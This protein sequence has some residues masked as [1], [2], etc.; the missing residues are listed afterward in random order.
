MYDRTSLFLHSTAWP[1][2]GKQIRQI[3]GVKKM[4]ED[5]TSKNDTPNEPELAGITGHWYLVR[6]VGEA[7]PNV[8][9]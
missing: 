2:F 5:V 8:M 9:R 3:N 4:H 6:F 7:K 1:V